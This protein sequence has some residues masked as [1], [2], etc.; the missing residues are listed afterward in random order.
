MRDT[1][2]NFQERSTILL[3]MVTMLWPSQVVQLI[4]QETQGTWIWT[5]G[6]ED[7][8]EQETAI[9]SSIFAWKI[10]WTKD[11]V[12]C[13]SCG[14][15]ELYLT[16]H[17]HSTLCY[18]LHPYK[19]FTL[20]QKCFL[21]TFNPFH[22]FCPAPT[23]GSHWSALYILSVW[24]F[25]FFSHFTYE[26]DHTIFVFLWLFSF[27]IMPSRSTH[28]V[29]NGKILFILWL[30]KIPLPVHIF[31]SSLSIHPSMDTYI[32]SISWLL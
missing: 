31:M 2:S 22:P 14:C 1:L 25:L 16:E 30:S 11:L 24:A 12:G 9:H 20:Y 17:M 28:V 15:K 8:L 4:I 23:S 29:T 13:H 26:W 6:G 7:P 5:L 10:P 27:S 19:L 18:T 32:A 21:I 3:A